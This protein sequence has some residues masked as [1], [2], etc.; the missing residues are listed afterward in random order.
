MKFTL[1]VALR[2]LDPAAN[3]VKDMEDVVR[4]VSKTKRKQTNGYQKKFRE[5][6]DNYGRD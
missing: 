4:E 5:K 3:I 6:D 2:R 1:N